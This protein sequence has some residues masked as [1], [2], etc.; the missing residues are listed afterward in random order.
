[1]NIVLYS[2]SG[3]GN[4]GCEAIVRGT[5]NLLEQNFIL[6]SNNPQEDFHYGL[7]SCCRIEKAGKQIRPYSICHFIVKMLSFVDK[8]IYDKYSAK[9]LLKREEEVFFSIGGDAYCYHNAAERLGYLNKRLKEQRKK[10]ILWGCSIEPN[11]LENENV[12]ADM[13]RYHLIV[14]REP[15]TY[16]KLREL[17]ME[18]KTCLLPDPAFF[19]ESKEVKLPSVFC[20]RKVVGI[21]L[22]PLVC[23]VN[24]N[25]KK[26]YRELISYLINSNEYNVLLIPHV[27][28]KHD[29][30]RTVLSEF[31][32]E[33]RE[34]GRVE[35]ITDDLDCRELKYIISHC[36]FVVTARTHVSI[37]AY[38]TS[39][40]TLVVGYSVKALGIATELFDTS[41]HYVI[42][43]RIMQENDSLVNAFDW[44]Q[45][46][47]DKI[48]E[49]LKERNIRY[50]SEK[51]QV[52]NKIIELIER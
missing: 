37:A 48:K 52:K 5:Q 7:D 12:V 45:K 3:S 41:E 19:L 24:P 4:H 40:P 49:R 18:E 30:D 21:N 47:E 14:A 28:W 39:V 35:M 11:L 27:L 1:M 13:K 23:N 15:L 32:D 20:D 46:N 9:Y 22:S 51:Q 17:G 43:S 33:Y 8:H 16:Q 26:C 10:T 25:L 2:H 38:S 31:L 29:D 6:M 50:F 42:D 34:S 36:D 44:I